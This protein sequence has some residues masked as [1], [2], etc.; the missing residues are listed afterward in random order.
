MLLQ[1]LTSTGIDLRR[2]LPQTTR[3]DFHHR[4]APDQWSI[5]QIM[6]HLV[7]V[8]WRYLMRLQHVVETEKPY[9]PVILPDETAYDPQADPVSLLAQFEQ[10]RG[11]TIAFLQAISRADWQR[12]AV[13]ETNGETRFRYLVQHLVD[14][15]TEHLNQIV[16]VQALLRR[17]G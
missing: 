4:P 14:H 3:L 11:A 9:L 13:H 15:D 7:D 16:E 17:P 5:A 8:E 12:A 6:S 2:M 1:A 10:R